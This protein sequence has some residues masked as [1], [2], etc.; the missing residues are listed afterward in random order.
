MNGYAELAPQVAAGK[1]RALAI[2]SDERLPGIDVPTLKEQGVDVSLA[3]W[4]GIVAPPG[5]KDA[6][7]KALSDA[8][9]KM[10]DSPAWKQ[11]IA[12]QSLFDWI[13]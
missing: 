4:R 13:F 5:I 3:N 1:L 11:T 9:A 2:S 7:R 12:T 8:I 6:D 10:V